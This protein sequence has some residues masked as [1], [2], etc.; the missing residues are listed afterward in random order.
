M[1]Y[2][3]TAS[4]LRLREPHCHIFPRRSH[5]HAPPRGGASEQIILNETGESLSAGSGNVAGGALATSSAVD[6]EFAEAVGSDNGLA[7][8]ST[9]HNHSLESRISSFDSS[10]AVLSVCAWSHSNQAND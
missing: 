7:D 10:F 4:G 9:S 2:V 5:P 8:P 6:E 3:G 1:E